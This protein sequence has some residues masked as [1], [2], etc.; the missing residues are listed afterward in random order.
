MALSS[1]LGNMQEAMTPAPTGFLEVL[2]L[3]VV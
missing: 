3:Q 2:I 1:V